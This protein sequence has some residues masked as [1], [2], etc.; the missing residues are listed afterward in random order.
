MRNKIFSRIAVEV[1]YI[2]QS[3]LT[4]NCLQIKNYCWKRFVLWKHQNCSADRDF[5]SPVQMLH[6][7]CGLQ[8]FTS[9]H[10]SLERWCFRNHRWPWYDGLPM[11]TMDFDGKIIWFSPWKHGFFPQLKFFFQPLIQRLPK[12]YRLRNRICFSWRDWFVKP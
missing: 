11:L 4:N 6:V 7:I 2:S 1:T 3:R 5:S 9:K 12:T 10:R 8:S